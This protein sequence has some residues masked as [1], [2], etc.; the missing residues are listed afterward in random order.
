M[1]RL[2][3]LQA[4]LAAAILTVAGALACG[5][6]VL[7]TNSQGDD[8]G[9]DGTS[10]GDDASV[11]PRPPPDCDAGV[12]PV[13]L[14]CTELYSDWT[15]LTVAPDVQPYAPGATMWADEADSSRWIWLPPGSKIDTTDPNNWSFPVG[16]K[17]WEELRLLGKRVE[18]RFLWKEDAVDWFRTT[19][20]WTQ[21]QS[22]ATSVTLGVPNAMGLAYEIPPVSQ[23][24]TCHGGAHDFVLGF[25]EVGLALPKSSGLNLQALIQR[26]LLTKPPA[27][28][29]TLPGSDANTLASL[30]FLH[31]NCGTSCHN[32]NP[33]APANDL[34]LFLK[35]TTDATG[36]LPP[37]A[38][39]TDTW[40][41]AYR[42]PS[43]VTPYGFEAGGFWR[44]APGDVAHSSV[45]WT[46]GRRD[47][48]PTQM[49]PIATHLIDEDDL[50]L[51][52]SWIATM[53]K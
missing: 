35:L 7:P 9:D 36:A 15:Q 4:A 6:L 26:G 45:A 17:L 51:I 8:G 49:P 29:P 42:V 16:T 28:I 31:A 33:N 11:D 22:A 19:F 50:Q 44:I 20:V 40:T 5:D 38:Q 39:A 46:M 13:A 30:A 52:T 43:L 3:L 47:G 48:T 18:T 34:G 27:A 1:H 21:D 37:T 53:P 25:E 32:R 23:C 14:A 2:A 12:A 41:T 10:A 24:G